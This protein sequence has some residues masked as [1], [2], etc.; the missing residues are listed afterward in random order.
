[1]ENSTTTPVTT[2]DTKLEYAKSLLVLAD[3]YTNAIEILEILVSEIKDSST[4]RTKLNERA[5]SIRQFII[6][7][8]NVGVKKIS[9]MA[10][11]LSPITGVGYIHNRKKNKREREV[12]E[13]GNSTLSHSEQLIFHYLQE[14]NGVTHPNK[15]IRRT[16]AAVTPSPRVN[17]TK[18][19][20]PANGVEFT[21]L[22]IAEIIATTQY[23]TAE[24]A[25][26]IEKMVPHL[27]SF[28]IIVQKWTLRRMMAEYAQ[29]KP[30]V[31]K[32]QLK[33]GRP[34]Y[35]TLEEVKQIADASEEF[36][37]KVISKEDISNM[38]VAKHSERY[39]TAGVKVLTEKKISSRSVK[40]YTALIAD[41]ANMSVS[42]SY[43]IKSTSRNVAENSVRGSIALAATVG[44]SHL[45]PVERYDDD[46][47]SHMKKMPAK[48][49]QLMEMASSTFGTPVYPIPPQY[50]Y[51]SDDT[52]VYTFDGTAKGKEEFVLVT[53]SSLA[54]RGTRAVYHCEDDKA[55]QGMRVKL[56]FTFS[57]IGTCF[58][59]VATVA[60]LKEREMPGKEFVHVKI[61]GFCIGGGGV[62]INN[63]EVGHLL[64]MRDSAGAEK[65]RFKWYQE[66]IL[67]PGINGHRQ[68]FGK[69]DASSGREIPDK[70]TAVSWCDGDLSQI[71]S[72]TNSVRRLSE[73]KVIANKQHAA[74]SGVEQPCDVSKVF[75]LLKAQLPKHTVRDIPAEQCPMKAKI[76]DAFDS[77]LSFMKLASNKKHALIDFI[78][79][80]PDIAAKI[81][82][83]K[84]IQQG[85]IEAGIIDDQYHRYP[86][87][88][89]LLGT[90]RR[91]IKQVEY[92]HIVDS[93]PHFLHEANINGH[94]TE[95]IYDKLNIPRDRNSNG[96]EILRDAGISQEHMQRS[97]I[98]NHEYQVELRE[99][100]V[101]AVQQE[102][103]RKQAIAD[104]KIQLLIQSSQDAVK[105]LQKKLCDANVTVEGEDV[106]QCTLSM[107][108][109]LNI[110]QLDAFIMARQ[111]I[112]TPAYASKSKLP[113]NKGTLEEAENKVE[114]KILV[115]FQHKDK[116]NTASL[117]LTSTVAA[118]NDGMQND[119]YLNPFEVIMLD[120]DTTVLPSQLL[121]NETWVKYVMDLFHLKRTTTE[122][123]DIDI[124][125][126][127]EL[128][129]MLRERLDPHLERR[130][131][132]Q[133]KRSH[134]SLK[135]ARKNLAA[136]AAYMILSNHV[137]DDLSCLKEEDT[138]LAGKTYKFVECSE[139][140]DQEGAYLYYDCNQG[141][142]VR[143]GK[144]TRR[145][146][147]VRGN[148][149]YRESKKATASSHFYFLYPSRESPRSSHNN[150]RGT[151]GI[152]E[153]LTQVVASG[154]TPT[155][156]E[157]G[158]LDKD[159]KEG[160]FLILDNEE[161]ALIRKSM[162]KG[163]ISDIQ[164]FHD[165]CAY[166]MEL[167]YD[168][169]ISPAINVSRS[170]G[171]ESV[172]GVFG[173]ERG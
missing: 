31:G 25:D 103:N 145:G 16:V 153:N 142:F 137:K 97:K 170:P 40:N 38:I 78:S 89:T 18:L 51:S 85:F 140:P 119:I 164:K 165:M 77:E 156:S 57:A 42:K 116:P 141:C 80:L 39:K 70:L 122:V 37:G 84:N 148:E 157:A 28:G 138:I 125:K 88:D 118:E 8:I 124:R 111:D 34:A 24:R 23:R 71:H 106:S 169:A 163:G 69:F 20:S 91:D 152:F 44:V 60:G 4:S 101:A 166:Q 115:A 133:S 17:R 12:I 75:M 64:L 1:M 19:P 55:M 121:R 123:F 105:C 10:N 108:S 150:R 72:I 49:L 168:L 100:R 154:F 15:R 95:D 35:C 147:S 66:E 87:F 94:I 73:N 143:S 33:S 134:W 79:V 53:K 139:V 151:R 50:I 113:K 117:Q 47:L 74:R 29:G 58:P 11:T 52:T 173:G 61:P 2:T 171:F 92:D 68:E 160:G 9:K 114:N 82:T 48:T 128:V 99:E 59:L 90:C 5:R 107:F 126:A 144:V 167:A 22:E 120:C 158:T 155:S 172:L 27:A 130:I 83:K 30:I 56:T 112:A 98:L 65:Q 131:D 6:P 81:I 62:N 76:G 67:F 41:E 13:N 129:S 127:D 136:S 93:F 162:G 46:I 7:L 146:F 14:S 45:L 159:W 86:V 149:H 63:K 102:I 26:I 43:V 36:K 32:F 109:S 21:K 132:E 3:R 96:N 54:K 135:F 110:P 161:K 104:S